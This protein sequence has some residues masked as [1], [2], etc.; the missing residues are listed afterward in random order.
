MASPSVKKLTQE[1]HDEFLVCKICLEPYKNPKCLSCLHT[2][3]EECIESHIM[4]EVTYKKYIDYRDFTCPLCRKRTQLPIGGVRKLADNFL[5]S[6][7]SELVRR[8]RPSKFPS[9]DIC[10]SLNGKSREAIS[11]CLDCA[12]ILCAP[13][14][15]LHRSV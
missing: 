9:C 6:G 3:C 5:V 1:I 12:K 4:S 11:K 7:L 14:V 2:F 10:R 13:C 15:R 8:Q